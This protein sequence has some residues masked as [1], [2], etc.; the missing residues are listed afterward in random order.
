MDA[1]ITYAT[2]HTL[3]NRAYRRSAGQTHMLWIGFKRVPALTRV[4]D[5]V[6]WNHRRGEEAKV[7]RG[8]GGDGRVIWELGSRIMS[9]RW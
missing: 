8:F 7:Q 1:L 3:I 5:V 2:V 6:R 9:G 4:T